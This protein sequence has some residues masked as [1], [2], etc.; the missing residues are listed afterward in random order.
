MCSHGN[1][2]RRNLK[3]NNKTGVQEMTW[4]IQHWGISVGFFFP[5]FVEVEYFYC[6]VRTVNKYIKSINVIQVYEY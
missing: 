4:K 2:N 3:G 1:V 6:C 5:I